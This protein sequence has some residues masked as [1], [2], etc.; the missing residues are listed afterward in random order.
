MTSKYISHLYSSFLPWKLFAWTK[1]WGVVGK[2][3]AEENMIR[4]KDQIQ[5]THPQIDQVKQFPTPLSLAQPTHPPTHRVDKAPVVMQQSNAAKHPLW[6]SVC[7]L[8]ALE[9]LYEWL[10]FE[11]SQLWIQWRSQKCFLSFTCP[12]C[13]QP[14][15][16]AKLSL[17]CARQSGWI[18]R[19]ILIPDS[20]I[21]FVHNSKA[22]LPLELRMVWQYT[23][24]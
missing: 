6:N 7:A 19:M 23:C 12:S 8:I 14:C 10:V 17:Y 18:S 20:K 9:Q 16:L 24:S 5:T 22:N 1:Y 2:L 13:P 21:I 15:W 4:W 3:V 11:N